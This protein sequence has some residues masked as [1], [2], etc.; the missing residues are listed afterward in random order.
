MIIFFLLIKIWQFEIIMLNN[1]CL[2][3]KKADI[4]PILRIW[5]EFC[6]LRNANWFNL[7]DE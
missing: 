5:R 7:S 6:I 4:P 1:I 3:P 2:N